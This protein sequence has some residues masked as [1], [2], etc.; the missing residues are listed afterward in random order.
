MQKA[1]EIMDNLND[2]IIE[3]RN[4]K[5]LT[6]T[7]V[8]EKLGIKCS[9]YSQMERQ[10]IVSAERLFKLSEIFEVS[11]CMLFKGEEPCKIN[12][13]NILKAPE[14]IIPK[15]EVFVAT[16]KEQNIIKIMRE[17][18]KSDYNRVMELIQ[19]LYSGKNL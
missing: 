11:P 19:D 1:S 8:A 16:K 13:K 6:Q 9:T 12:D 10:G 7:E 2:R 5:D 17:L 18:D 14:P 3:Y 4:I 15:T